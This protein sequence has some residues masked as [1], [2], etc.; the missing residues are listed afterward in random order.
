[1]AS[2]INLLPY[3]PGFSGFSSYVNRL[4]PHLKG[5]YLSL[6]PSPPYISFTSQYIVPNSL[7]SSFLLRLLHRTSFAQ[8]IYDL[9]KSSLQSFEP[10]SFSCVYSPFFDYFFAF[11]NSPQI[12]TVHDLTPLFYSNSKRAY[13]RYRLLAPMHLRRADRIVCISRFVADQ[14]ISLGLPSSKL[15]VVYNSVNLPDA[16]P[17]LADLHSQQPRPIVAIARHDRNKGLIYLLAGY[18]A[19]VER[20]PL[21]TTPPQLVIIGKTGPETN[22]IL[23]FIRSRH[24]SE[25]VVIVSNVSSGDLSRY[26]YSAMCFVSCS[27]MEGFNLTPLEA[28]AHSCPCILSDIPVHRELY[29]SAA[30]FFELSPSSN[31]LAEHLLSICQNPSL[32]IDLRQ[33]GSLL[34]HSFS[35]NRQVT[36]ISQLINSYS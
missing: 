33:S 7:P 25:H 21:G 31:A 14:L 22:S 12:I 36:A 1:M 11:S 3:T 32:S 5:T 28:M 18:S 2:L 9:K 34:V 6:T 20:L 23:R 24:L 4:C 10:R 27:L 17:P 29:S 8:H 26:L 35:L 19:F 15:E 16:S 30:L 13:L